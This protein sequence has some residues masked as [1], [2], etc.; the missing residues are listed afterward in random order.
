MIK[1]IIVDDEPDARESLSRVCEQFEELVLVAQC[2]DGESAIN[3]IEKHRPDIVFLDIEMPEKGGFEVASHTMQMPYLLVFVSAFEHYALDAF[4]TKAVD[5]LLKPVRPSRL[6]QCIDKLLALQ[7][8]II[9]KKS[10]ILKVTI[11]DSTQ[12]HVLKFDEIECIES[13]GRYQGLQLSE[14]GQR[15]HK[16]NIII[17]DLTLDNF[18]QLLNQQYFVRIHRSSIVNRSF[19]INLE[20][21]KNRHMVTL[22]SGKKL[23][24]SRPNVGI[25]KQIL[26]K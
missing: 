14:Q 11:K 12:T 7:A 15:V 16:Q 10:E 4:K 1:V 6:K 24:I 8:E 18:E 26:A 22:R 9:N 2:G 19:I 25:I 23:A 3:A 13:I 5:Y 20:R 17:T 21:Q